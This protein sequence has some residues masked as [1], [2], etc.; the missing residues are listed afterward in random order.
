MIYKLSNLWE[1]M[2]KNRYI[3][4]QIYTHTKTKKHSKMTDKELLWKENVKLHQVNFSSIKINRL[5]L[6]FK[7]DI[8]TS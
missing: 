3:H 8:L 1:F 7:S 6:T 5:S 2:F 4:T